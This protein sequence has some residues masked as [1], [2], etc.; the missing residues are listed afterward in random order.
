MN[1]LISELVASERLQI[2]QSQVDHVLPESSAR[3]GQRLG[4]GIS[5][6]DDIRS[7]ADLLTAFIAY[8][9]YYSLLSDLT[10]A[11]PVFAEDLAL[12][13][14]WLRDEIQDSKQQQWR[15]RYRAALFFLRTWRPAPAKSS[16]RSLKAAYENGN[17]NPV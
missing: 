14:S 3:P 10:W 16:N 7:D 17:R 8:Y 2:I 6:K 12:H 5:E 13:L 15:Y 1:P 9:D 11:I 4:S